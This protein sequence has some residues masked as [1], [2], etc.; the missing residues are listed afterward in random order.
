MVICGYVEN[1]LS[2]QK[3]VNSNYDV[4]VP[5]GAWHNIVNIGATPLKLY[6]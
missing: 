5:A 6:S 1:T 3:K 2:Y 4:L